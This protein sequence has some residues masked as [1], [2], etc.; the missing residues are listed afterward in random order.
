MFLFLLVTK[1]KLII[2]WGSA[3]AVLGV[4]GSLLPFMIFQNLQNHSLKYYWKEIYGDETPTTL[5]NNHRTK[6]GNSSI[7]AKSNIQ[8]N[9]TNRDR[10]VR[11][12]Y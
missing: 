7:K 10:M 1:A 2:R 5:G 8:T 4:F 9:K 12:F 11:R 6:A 3:I